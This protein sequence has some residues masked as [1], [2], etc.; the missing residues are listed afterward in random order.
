LAQ[1]DT[2]RSLRVSP[3]SQLRT[4]RTNARAA[5]RSWRSQSRLRA[6]GK[7][8]AEPQRISPNRSLTGRS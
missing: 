3:T 8:D 6:S 7:P 4:K 5:K 1:F 2:G